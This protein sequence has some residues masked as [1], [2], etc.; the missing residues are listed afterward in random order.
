MAVPKVK[1]LNNVEIKEGY[2]INLM[3]ELFHVQSHSL[4]APHRVCKEAYYKGRSH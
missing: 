2:I 1:Y 4:R 3:L